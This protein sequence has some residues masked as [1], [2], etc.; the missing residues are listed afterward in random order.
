MALG[1]QAQEMKVKSFTLKQEPMTVPMQRR[2][3]NGE[4]CALVKVIIPSAQASFEGNII[5]NCDYKTSEYWCY[6]SP[7][8]K[9]LKVKY[10]N[11]EPLIVEFMTSVESK[12]IYELR[13][14]I[15]ME[16]SKQAQKIYTLSI[17]AHS[18][19]SVTLL[20]QQRFV[21]M[22]G[23]KVKRYNH[24][25]NFIDSVEYKGG[26][27]DP[28][29][30]FQVGAVVGDKLEISAKGYQKHVVNFNDPANTSYQ[31][32]LVP[33]IRNVRFILKDSKNKETLIGASIYKNYK[34]KVFSISSQWNNWSNSNTQEIICDEM[35]LTDF[36]GSTEV[37]FS[38]KSTDSFL[39]Q[40]NGYKDKTISLIQ[41]MDIGESAGCDTYLIELDPYDVGETKNIL[42]HIGGM[43]MDD[44]G[45]VTVNNSRTKESFVMS[46]K[47]NENYKTTGVAIGDELRFVRR[48][49]RTVSVK[50]Q[51]SI[52]DRIDIAPLKGKKEDVQ[53]LEY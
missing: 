48:G 9:Q 31:V 22:E 26:I 24:Y 11:C 33:K 20:G 40:Y 5:G 14:E 50:F 45:N 18:T 19:E 42:I 53:Y 30:K 28:E 4:V 32:A 27:M 49:F 16:Y 15:P 39:F 7:G 44:R 3:L 34:R 43:G 21:H 12:Q 38:V 41:N 17:S 2:D 36:E 52:P 51:N 8:S 29:Y 37:F 46:Q 10:P 23:V 35:K 47:A 1:L 25:G 6:L 13:L